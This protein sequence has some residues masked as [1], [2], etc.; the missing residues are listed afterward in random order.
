[1]M[2][3]IFLVGQREYIENLRTKT[4]WIGIF[5][6]PI[7][8]TGS[9]V[10][11]T[12]L[13]RT[14]G[15][16]TY[17]VVDH[18]GWLLQEI[19]DRAT[20]PDMEKVF[21]FALER[22]ERGGKEFE[23]LPMELQAVATQIQAGME[24]AAPQLAGLEGEALEAKR[25]EIQDQLL[26]GF[27]KVLSGLEGPEGQSL[28]GML[29]PDAIEGLALLREAIRAWWTDLPPDEAAEFGG[30]NKSRYVLETIPESEA[31]DLEKLNRRIAD[32]ELFAYFVI[33]EDPVRG[34]D[35]C[36]YVSNNLTDDDLMDWFTGIATDV[37]Q[38]RRIAEGDIE[39]ETAAWIQA[40]LRFKARKVGSAGAEEEVEDSDMLRQW[41]PVAFV[42]VLWLAIFSIS[43]NL[44]TNTV[45]EKSNRILEVLLS[46]V[47]PIELMAGKIAGIAVT[48]LTVVVTWVIT[49]I[50]VVKFLPGMLGSADMGI[51]LSQIASDPI[52]L[53]SFLSYFLLG[54]LLYAALLVGIGAV[55]NSLKEA[56][57][58]MTP[59]TIM[60]MLPLF[61]MIPIGK[62]PNGT[63]AK[64]LS[65]VPPFTP[66]VMMN[67]AAGPPSTMEYV[68]TTLL[69]LVAVGVALWGA[70]KIFRIGILMTGK[71]PTPA[72]IF[73]WLRTPVGQV[74]DRAEPEHPGS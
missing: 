44:L 15:P 71:A 17:A 56:Q 50:L 19:E 27:A 14:K 2:R 8:L 49:F 26:D 73:K 53:G 63:L 34:S 52:Y 29:P 28:A 35:G 39:P 64:V 51:N 1:M 7:I 9:I 54:Y 18:S 69:L 43:Q 67:R 48:G 13:E 70:A 12:L 62:D 20:L 23:E 57:N 30:D 41:A 21:R 38:E 72:E 11:P 32:E 3:K 68:L 59:V 22:Q 16:R 36:R 45:E 10:V 74:P 24:V 58:L 4:F 65:Y 37:I 33:G 61:A 40:P 6:F 42:Y 55:C 46:S 66:F 5:L 31:G 47:S 25:T 60:L